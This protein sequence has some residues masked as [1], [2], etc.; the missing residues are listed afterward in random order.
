MEEKFWVHGSG[1]L[2]GPG[3]SLL[4]KDEER[5]SVKPNQKKTT[6]RSEKLG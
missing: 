3:N 2:L 6:F 5:V 1:R 4:Q